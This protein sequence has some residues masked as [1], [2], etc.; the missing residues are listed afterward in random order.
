MIS[1]ALGRLAVG[2]LLCVVC[3]GLAQPVH[4]AD[5]LEKELISASK[6]VL[7]HARENGYK[8]IGVL[9]FAVKNH[10]DPT[11][12]HDSALG[13]RLADKLEMALL[14]TVD[15]SDPIGIAKNA[16]DTAA[17]IAGASHL[18]PSQEAREKLFVKNYPMSWGSQDQPI[19]AFY[20]GSAVLLKDLSKIV[21]G[22]RVLD[23]AT[24]SLEWV[25]N[26]R[27]EVKP[28]IDELMDAGQS[29]T[30]RGIFDSANIKLTN[31][32]RKEKAAEEAT[33]TSLDVSDASDTQQTGSKHPLSPDNTDSPITFEVHYD[34]QPQKIRIEGGL[35]FVAEPEEHQKVMFVIRRKG[36]ARPRLA[37][38]VKVNGEN[39]LRKQTL[40]DA[41]C[42]AWI[43]EPHMDVFGIKGYQM[44]QNE[45]EPFR[46]LSD[47][48]SIEK[49]IDYGSHAGAITVSV[50][51][52]LKGTPTET[53]KETPK[54][55]SDDLLALLEDAE[56]PERKPSTLAALR[57]IL[58]PNAKPTP[59]VNQFATRGLIGGG[60]KVT[61]SVEKTKMQRDSVPLMSAT[62]RYYNPSDLP[63]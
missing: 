26:L 1:N 16:S 36:S 30:T 2:L 18:S 11:G 29:F 19:D 44:N 37:V 39:T 47:S 33:L 52:E 40:P 7:K 54:A 45:R 5:E 6:A 15:V 4:A 14:L 42:G 43:F 9:K 22:F 62:L 51:P 59:K 61:A 25:P 58:D 49:E 28:G 32:E 48:E 63:E 17:T 41:K 31:T 60:D 57:S 12:G 53:P 27:L 3:S 23:A 56:H 46:V 55:P 50:F 38:V 35:A 24:G 21:V 8:N 20:S 13:R 34:N 10:H